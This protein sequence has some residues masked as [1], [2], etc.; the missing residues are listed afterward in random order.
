MVYPIPATSGTSAIVYMVPKPSGVTAT[1]S[2]IETP[3]V[4]DRALI[5]YATAQAFYKDGKF[6][7]GDRLMQ[8][9]TS[10]LDRFRMDFSDKTSPKKEIVR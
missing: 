4:Y 5:I 8:Q 10:E 6:G 9:Y 2:A 7:F 3:A 1:T